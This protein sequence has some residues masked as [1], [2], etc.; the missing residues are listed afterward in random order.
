MTNKNRYGQYFTIDPIAEFMVSLISHSSKSRVLE[1]SCGKGIFI[2][3]LLLSGF[4]NI[5]AYE[6][7]YTLSTPY[8]CVSY[9]SFLNVPIEQRYEVVIGNPPYIRW[10]N[11]ET[12]LKEELKQNTLWNKYFNSLCDY[13]FIFILKSIEHLEDNGELIFICTEY[14]LNTTHSASL[15]DYICT[16]GYFSDI[17]HFNETPLFE[18]VAASFII[19]R[20]VKSQSKSESIRLHQYN[21]GKSLPTI[22]ELQSGV[23]FS[24]IS[25]PQF[26]KGSR[27]VLASLETQQSLKSFEEI[28]SYTQ[29]GL[30][31]TKRLHTIGD[32][33]DIGNGMVSGLDNAFQINDTSHLLPEERKYLI[34]VLKAKDLSPY[35]KRDVSTY[36]F[37]TDKIEEQEFKTKFPNLD[38]HFQPHLERLA[39]RY[40]YNKNIPYWEFV[41]PR[42]QK[43]FERE[44]AKIFIPCKERI[45]HKSYFRFCYAD[46]GYYPTQDVTAIVRKKGCRESIEYILAYLNNSR[47]FNWLS[48]HGIIKGNI[49]EFS[50]SPI[51]TIPFR[52]IN[53]EKPHEIALHDEIKREVQAY[54][55]D[56]DSDHKRK[57][58]SLFNILFNESDSL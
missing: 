2:E 34:P 35:I 56:E 31:A 36:I 12:E 44:E 28:C 23:C 52:A 5:D 15:R 48:L 38:K 25:I 47:V 3:K 43:L 57:I 32:Y 26:Q 19:F 16:H 8:Q 21:K 46:S 58:N 9:T 53:W 37:I 17:Y 51:S 22:T 40:N 42:N 1:P 49:V 24:T 6:I 41:F 55:V 14:W 33:C 18:K 50:E 45:S 13:L 4:E 7:D 27:W 11:L 39:K 30:F 29:Q 54:L 10:K 20:F